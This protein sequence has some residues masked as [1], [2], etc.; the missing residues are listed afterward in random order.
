MD[1]GYGGDDGGGRHLLRS[2]GGCGGH[3]RRT[4]AT[5]NLAAA[6]MVLPVKADG[7]EGK[8]DWERAH[9]TTP[10]ALAMAASIR[11][12]ASFSKAASPSEILTQ[13]PS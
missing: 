6:I 10:L 2:A 8:G 3:L 7:A 11:A 9:A 13:I 5:A 4:L 1:V 12:H